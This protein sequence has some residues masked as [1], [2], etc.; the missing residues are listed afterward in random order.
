MASKT[1]FIYSTMSAPVRYCA[2]VEGGGDLP[3]PQ[4]GIVIAGGTGV[5]N[6]N[7]ITPTGAVATRVTG[8]QLEQLRT[9]RVFNEHL[10]NGY[11]LVSAG[12]KDAEVVASD[13]ESRDASAPLTPQ[14]FEATGQ[15]AP[16]VGAPSDGDDDKAAR[17]SPRRA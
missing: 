9:D 12:E 8:E 4:D 14:D 16:Q 10:K 11:L 17:K 1:H 3:V 7:L 5:A 6:K 13:M 2:A 15:A